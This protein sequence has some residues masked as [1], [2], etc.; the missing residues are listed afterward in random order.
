VRD[1][2]D[3]RTEP[4]SN[5]VADYGVRKAVENLPQLR[6]KMGAVIDNY[7]DVQQDILETSIHLVPFATTCPSFARKASSKRSN[8]RGDTS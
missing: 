6:E 2:V 5:N 4:A 7:L 3:L 8:A 1:H